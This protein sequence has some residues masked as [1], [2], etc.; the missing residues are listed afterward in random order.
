MNFMKKI[1][2]F[3]ER[4]IEIE[5]EDGV[6]KDLPISHGMCA[7]CAILEYSD[8]LLGEV[9]INP[10]TDEEFINDSEA[11]AMIEME[12]NAGIEWKGEDKSKFALDQQDIYERLLYRVKREIKENTESFREGGMSRR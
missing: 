9:A 5:S 11:K 2:L 6:Y 7:R 10:E 3:C 4:Y 12:I 1:C 8:M